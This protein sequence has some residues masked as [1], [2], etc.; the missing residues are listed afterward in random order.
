[1]IIFD[2]VFA[3]I[4]SCCFFQ[5]QETVLQYGT[6]APDC[7]K[8]HN[9]HCNY[10]G[11]KHLL[12][13]FL[14]FGNP[15]CQFNIR[16]VKSEQQT[17]WRTEKLS[18]YYLYMQVSNTQIQMYNNKEAYALGFFEQTCTAKVWE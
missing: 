2:L 9:I 16:C 11:S 18:L 15:M 3:V 13:R 14:Y 7:H 10:K 8:S 1:M 6:H 12:D 17:Q 4:W 5:I